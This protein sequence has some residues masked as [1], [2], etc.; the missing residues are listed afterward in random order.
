MKP[1]STHGLYKTGYWRSRIADD[2]LLCI[3]T[4][5]LLLFQELSAASTDDGE[6]QSGRS[7][8]DDEAP[9]WEQRSVLLTIIGFG[10][11]AF[12]WNLSDEV[13]PTPQSP[14]VGVFCRCFGSTWLRSWRCIP[15][16]TTRP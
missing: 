11:V 5:T 15:S 2:A 10:L 12:I 1:C 14:I 3:Y 8:S 9:W 6:Q 16:L 4:V 13:L 7:D